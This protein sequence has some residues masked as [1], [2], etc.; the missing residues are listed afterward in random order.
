MTIDATRCN[1]KKY[2]SGKKQLMLKTKSYSKIV[3]TNNT[4]STIF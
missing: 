4:K 1:E 2:F 3:V